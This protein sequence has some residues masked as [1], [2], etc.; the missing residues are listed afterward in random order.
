[1]I[2][3]YFFDNILNWNGDLFQ[4]KDFYTD[5]DLNANVNLFNEGNDFWVLFLA[6]ETKINKVLQT[7]SQMIMETLS[8]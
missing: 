2:E 4:I 8:S 3:L 7:S 1:M 5:G 6:N